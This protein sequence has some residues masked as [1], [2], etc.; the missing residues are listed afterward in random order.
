QILRRV[1]ANSARRSGGTF[2]QWSSGQGG[3]PSPPTSLPST[4]LV[5]DGFWIRGSMPPG[6]P[7]FWR[8]RMGDQ[9][10]QGQTAFEPG[11][12]GMFIFTGTLPDAAEAWLEN[13]APADDPNWGPGSLGGLSSYRTGLSAGM[14]QDQLQ[15]EQE[16][17]RQRQRDRDEDERRRRR[18]EE[19][20]RRHSTPVEPSHRYPSAY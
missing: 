5:N 18:D 13:A 15:R 6:T 12:E 19:E 11:P 2:Q 4:R 9:L 3:A 8:W 17:E 1:F 10:S 7:V 20:S 16:R 14:L